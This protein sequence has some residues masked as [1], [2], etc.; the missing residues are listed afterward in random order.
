MCTII[1]YL[2]LM[3]KIKNNNYN[4][5]TAK[6]QKNESSPIVRYIYSYVNGV[7]TP[8]KLQATPWGWG[9]RYINILNK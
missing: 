4:S 2:N 1:F 6:S 7:K 3:S 5:S 8:F 9:L